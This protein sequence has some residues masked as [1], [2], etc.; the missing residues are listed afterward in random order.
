MFKPRTFRGFAYS[1]QGCRSEN[2]D[3]YLIIQTQDQ[4][5]QARYLYNQQPQTIELKLWNRG[6][7]RIAVADGMGGHTDGRLASESLINQLLN[8]AATENVN[9]L[10]AAVKTIHKKLLENLPGRGQTR[11]GSTLVMADIDIDSGLCVIANVGDS[12]AYLLR[13]GHL[14][15]LSHDHIYCEFAWRDGDIKDGQ[16]FMMRQAIDHHLTQAMGFGSH[17]IIR[18]TDGTRPYQF[19]PNLRLDFKD[20]GQLWHEGWDESLYQ[21]RDVFLLQLLPDD[22]LLLASDGLWSTGTDSLWLPQ[23][24]MPLTDVTALEKLVQDALQAGSQDNITVVMCARAGA[25]GGYTALDGKTEQLYQHS[26]HKLETLRQKLVQP[27]LDRFE[28]LDSTKLKPSLLLAMLVLFWIIAAGRIIYLQSQPTVVSVPVSGISEDQQLFEQLQNSTVLETDNQK[29][30]VLKPVDYHLARQSQHNPLPENEVKLL[31]N[32]YNSIAGQVVRRQIDIWNQTREFSAVR[33]SSE[34]KWQLFDANGFKPATGDTVPEAFGFV[35]QKHLNADYAYGALRTE[36]YDWQVAQHSDAV[37]YQRTVPADDSLRSQYIG[38]LQ[39][40]Q[41]RTASHTQDCQNA[42]QPLCKIGAGLTKV[43]DCNLTIANAGE[44]FLNRLPA[45]ATLELKLAAVAN[46][47]DKVSGLAISYQCKS[48]DCNAINKQNFTYQAEKTLSFAHQEV[49]DTRFTI[50]T[51]DGIALTDELGM[52][53][54]KAKELGLTGLIGTDKNDVGRLS[55]LM[56]KSYF[57]DNTVLQLTLDSKIQQ[58]AQQTLTDWFAHQAPKDAYHYL[59]R[60][61]LVVLDADNGDI[62]ASASFPQPPDGVDWTKKAWDKAVFSSRYY[63]LD[64]FLNRPWQGGDANQAP[65]STFKVLIALA[66]AQRIKE[67]K[68]DPANQ[69]LVNYFKGLSQAQFT[70]L[71]GLKMSDSQL[72]VFDDEYIKRGAKPFSIDNFAANNGSAE[73]MADFYNKSLTKGCGVKETI[74]KNR[75]GVAEALRDSSNV[76]FAELA[77]LMDGETAQFHDLQNQSGEL[78][79]TLKRFMKKFGF[80]ENF[81][82]LAG[83]DELNNKQQA[84]WTKAGLLKTPVRYAKNTAPLLVS[85]TDAM[86]NL[87]QTAIGQSLFVTPLEMAQVA[88]LA[89]TGNWLK[90]NLITQWADEPVP[91]L[92]QL[93]L[94]DSSKNLIR[95]G[96]AAV[97]QVGTAH[98]AFTGHADRCRVYGKTGTAQVG[99]T[100]SSLA[101]YNT[102]WFIGWREPKEK[103]ESLEN[104]D[105]DA[106]PSKKEKKLAFACMVTHAHKSATGGSVCAPI[107]ADF[108]TRVNHLAGK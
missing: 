73:R 30:L 72:A 17:G 10:A 2:E 78:D 37:T 98:E 88:V 34:T 46:P 15:Q 1:E 97:V 32:V 80:A 91:P 33:D 4:T 21:H 69:T 18:D 49:A 75:L 45:T 41:L 26:K 96:L 7:L 103:P 71:T 81:S 50:Q 105:V 65:G 94:E 104:P 28:A 5:T 11:P 48:A 57:A 23:L 39:S 53:S 61:A 38:K 85:K 19:N 40:C 100:S 20:D 24:T 82:L 93:S 13:D 92:A 36:F 84:L 68:D 8:T 44:I 29:R 79:L 107:V 35:H 14:H 76:W 86:M 56:A 89:A 90:P 43:S 102:A 27:F 25:M 108:L 87:T 3:N 64:P 101:P 77:K 106:M 16:Y 74:L 83:V 22:V 47:I 70:Q 12:R 59:R 6:K 9:Q 60:G 62:L 31:S 67:L 55:Y 95:T 63:Q 52:L 99:R 51:A 58:A 66:A 42:I 54:T